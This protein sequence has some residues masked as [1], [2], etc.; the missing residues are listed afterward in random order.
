MNNVLKFSKIHFQV[1][2][3]IL[4][5]FRITIIAKIVEVLGWV[6]I[7][8]S[9]FGVQRMSALAMRTTVWNVHDANTQPFSTML[10][11]LVAS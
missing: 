8:F 6:R 4:D 1:K 9:H 3:V 7:L 11:L 10:N 2:R 5:S